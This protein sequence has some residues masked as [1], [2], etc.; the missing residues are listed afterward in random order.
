[1]H[2]PH[3]LIIPLEAPKGSR[4]FPTGRWECMTRQDIMLTQQGVPT[5][6]PMH[7]TFTDRI[8]WNSFEW[9]GCLQEFE[10]ERGV[11]TRDARAM[12]GHAREDA[13]GY[14]ELGS[15]LPSP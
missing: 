5:L 9:F 15:H 10:R 2:L 11:T 3:Q 13:E 7:S 8:Q 14:Q 6:T 4:E 12:H 1:M